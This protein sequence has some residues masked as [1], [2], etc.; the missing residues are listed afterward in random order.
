MNPKLQVTLHKNRM[1]PG[2]AV[3]TIPT[4]VP[5]RLDSSTS[6]ACLGKSDK[7]AAADHENPTCD[8][9]Q[10]FGNIPTGTYTGARTVAGK[11]SRSYGP[12]KRFLLTA[13]GGQALEACKAPDPRW[14]LMIHG[15]DPL[16]SGGL[17]P[18]HGCLRLADTDMA[19]LVELVGASTLEVTI[20][21][22]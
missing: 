12:N 16:P 3:L 8:P 18:T 19:M 5:G 11:P 7:T 22:V 4:V 9:L 15:G 14:G 2:V 1:L 21:E 10:P 17:R 13:T 20:G 6:F